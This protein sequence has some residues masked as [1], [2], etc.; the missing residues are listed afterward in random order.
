MKHVTPLTLFAAIAV[1]TGCQS[2][3]RGHLDEHVSL[4]MVQE[5]SI[6]QDDQPLPEGTGYNQAPGQ[7][8]ER[9]NTREGANVHYHYHYHYPSGYSGAGYTGY[10]QPHYSA[11]GT[12]N[13]HHFPSNTGA[14]PMS[15]KGYTPYNNTGRY[16]GSSGYQPNPGTPGYGSGWWIGNWNPYAND[17]AGSIEGFNN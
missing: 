17:G 10:A 4:G 8:N 11:P 5:A 12:V 1:A 14:A 7:L 13:V 9:L 3:E 15:V 16:P 2:T 6:G